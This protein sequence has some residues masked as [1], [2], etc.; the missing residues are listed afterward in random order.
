[1]ETNNLK[2][3]IENK[4]NDLGAQVRPRLDAAKGH[5]QSWNGQVVGF[6]KD[7]PGISLAG[8]ATVGYLV[9]RLAR[10]ERS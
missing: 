2:E 9:A 3:R 10:R 8:A 4:V 5:L 7:H 1:M 6:I